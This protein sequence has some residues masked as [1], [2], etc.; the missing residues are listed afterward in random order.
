M[1]SFEE[2]SPAAGR[3]FKTRDGELVLTYLLDRFYHCRI[4][5]ETL[6][7]QVGQRDVLLH[8]KHLLEGSNEK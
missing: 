4:K 1:N 8:V 2:V 6:V 3:L 5:D 7:R